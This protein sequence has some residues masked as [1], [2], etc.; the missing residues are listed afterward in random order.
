MAVY[1]TKGSKG[2]LVKRI[3]EALHLDNN[4]FFCEKTEEAVKNI[5]KTNDIKADGIV[6]DVTWEFIFKKET[7]SDALNDNDSK[8]NEKKENKQKKK[9][10]RLFV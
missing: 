9:E 2:E 8:T 4:G 1:I 5:Q 6:D 7:P 10:R 3:Q